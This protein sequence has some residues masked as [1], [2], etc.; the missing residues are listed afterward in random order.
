[1]VFAAAPVLLAAPVA[2]FA[3]VAGVAVAAV[4]AAG[5]EVVLVGAVAA[6]WPAAPAEGV[7]AGAVPSVP[8]GVDPQP[9]PSD[10]TMHRALHTLLLFCMK[11]AL[12]VSAFPRACLGVRC[13]A[14]N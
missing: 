10:V 1:M 7:V 5:V 9:A 6:A 3:V 12:V 8:V 2:L 11:I 14:M 4:V 13:V